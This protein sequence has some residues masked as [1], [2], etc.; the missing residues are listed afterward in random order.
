MGWR[1]IIKIHPA[2]EQFPPMSTDE[3]KALGEDIKQNGMT[4]PITLCCMT[5]MIGRNSPGFWMAATVSTHWNRPVSMCRHYWQN[6]GSRDPR[7][8][9]KSVMS[10]CTRNIEMTPLSKVEVTLP[11]VLGSRGM[12]RGGGVDEQAG[13]QPA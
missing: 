1:D 3:L 9:S 11:R 8:N 5:L 10:L 6:V 13:V 12:R 2:A 4:A 7:G